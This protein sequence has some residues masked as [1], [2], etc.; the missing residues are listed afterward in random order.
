LTEQ[1]GLNQKSISVFGSTGFIGSNFL[2]KSR[3]D[4]IAIPRTQLYSQS[5]EILYLVG[6]VDNYNVFEDVNLD[7]ET[8]L[9]LFISTLETSRKMYPDLFVNYVS[10]WFVYGN[11]EIPYREDQPCN[12]KGFYSI[13]KYAA[14][15]LLRSYCETHSLG[16]RIIRLGNVLGPGDNKASL[17]KNAVQYMANKISRGEDVNLYEGGNMLRDFIHIDDVV[18]GLDLILEKGPESEI[19][20]LASGV[21]INIGELLHKLKAFTGSNSVLHKIETPKFHNLVQAKDSILDISKIKKLG[22]TITRPITE[23]ELLV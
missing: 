9:K 6:T 15:L 10:T 19:F 8:N 20:N 21:G 11:E 3:F 22:F 5:K 13:T 4:S 7:I 23:R 16:Y 2:R 1:T 12:P 14:E 18:L 17:K